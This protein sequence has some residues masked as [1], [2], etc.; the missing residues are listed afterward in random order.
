MGRGYESASARS[1]D[2]S[3]PRRV[4]V[5]IHAHIL[6]VAIVALALG[7]ATPDAH[8]ADGLEKA[9][10]GPAQVDGVSQFPIYQ[11]LRVT[12]F[13]TTLS[14]ADVAP[15]RPADERDPRDPAYRWPAEVD[16]AIREAER[17]GMKVLLMLISAPPWAN[18]GRTPEYAPDRPRDFADFARAAARRYP[19]V[20][21][22]MVWGE[23]SRSNNFKPFV[24][25]P[26]GTKI[27][28]A[29]KRAPRRYARLLDAAYG[30]L[31]AQRRSNIVIG[32]NTYTTGEVRPGDWMRA[33]KLPSGRPPRMSQY[34]HNPFGYRNPDLRNPPSKRGLVDFS[35]L[36]RFDE[37]LQRD[38]GKPLGKRIK[39]FLSEYTVATAA[40]IEFNF[41]VSHATQAKWIKSAFRVARQLGNVA[42]LGWVHLHD[43]QPI[44]G[45]PVIN[46]GLI[47]ADGKPKLGYYAFQRGG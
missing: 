17:H 23:P 22:W 37:E 39:L 42:G 41:Y 10:W 9:I 3:P 4:G 38:I 29:Q 20:R 43:D 16:Y 19:S 2:V 33:M 18:G 40:D 30:Q 24:K 14:W 11:D 35:D 28:A 32:G 5:R 8:A 7:A 27:T 26:L 6:A 44:A 34:G 1:A 15:T 25:Q 12:L 36:G 45:K 46:G 31:K 47:G 13:Q 21:H